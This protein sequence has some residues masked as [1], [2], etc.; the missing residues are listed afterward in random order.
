[1]ERNCLFCEIPIDK[2]KHGLVKFCSTQCRNKYYYQNKPDKQTMLEDI[3][4][5]INGNMEVENLNQQMIIENE[6]SRKNMQRCIGEKQ[7]INQNIDERTRNLPDTSRG[8]LVNDTIRYLE[9]NYR[10]KADL[11]ASQ[12]RYENALKEIEELKLKLIELENE[13]SEDEEENQPGILGML[14]EIPEWLQPAIGNLLKSEKVQ[15]YIIGLVP[16]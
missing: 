16:E 14:N 1:M 8:V 11:V 12:I 9:E 5:N 15:N 4:N 3:D 6:H 2:K 7:F 13:I 10:T